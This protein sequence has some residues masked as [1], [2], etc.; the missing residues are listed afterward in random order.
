MEPSTHRFICHASI[1]HPFV[2]DSRRVHTKFIVDFPQSTNNVAKSR[3]LTG[4][5]QVGALVDKLLVPDLTSP[6]SREVGEKW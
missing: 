1:P 6:A 3:Q 5:D 2:R 4:A